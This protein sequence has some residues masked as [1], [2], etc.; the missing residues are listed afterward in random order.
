[1]HLAHIFIKKNTSKNFHNIDMCNNQT[2]ETMEMSLYN[3]WIDKLIYSHPGTLYNLKNE[4]TATTCNT[5]GD[6]LKP[7][8]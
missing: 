5:M 7:N 2:L 3:R 1:M 6:S 8:I 4:T